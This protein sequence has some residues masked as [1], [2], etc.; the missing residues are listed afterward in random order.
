LQQADE[1]LRFAR[2]VVDDMYTKVAAG[3][4]ADKPHMTRLQWE[5]LYRAAEFY[6][7]LAQ[8]A[9]DDPQF[10]ADAAMARWRWATIYTEQQSYPEAEHVLRGALAQLERALAAVPDSAEFEHRWALVAMNLAWVVGNQDRPDE[11][12]KLA[13]AAAA[14]WERL[15]SRFPAERK[16][17]AQIIELSGNTGHC[18]LTLRPAEAET[19]LRRAIAGYEQLGAATDP[20]IN[21][22]ES[23][24]TSR[25]W[26][27]H[28]LKMQK[29][30]GE[31]KVEID[32][33][34]DGLASLD[35]EQAAQQVPRHLTANAWFLRAAVAKE[36]GDMAAARDAAAQSVALYE[37]VAKD[38]PDLEYIAEQRD[39]ARTLRKE[40]THKAATGGRAR[41]PRE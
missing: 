3:W 29:P 38:F 12:V 6:E 21:W 41:V 9:G 10:V 4:L 36:L 26:L 2:R 35:P 22:R 8:E 13:A 19:H 25:L 17:R 14:R 33:A 39:L 7:Q 20:P 16:Y 34:L 24:A 32:A 30:Y 18:L 40:L 15:A 11:A 5:F 31:A 27:G 37:E 28:A 1:R 23:L